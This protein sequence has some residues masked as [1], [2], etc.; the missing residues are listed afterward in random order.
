[1]EEKYGFKIPNWGSSLCGA[2]ETNL[3]GIREDAG[4]IPGLTHWVGN[5]V[6]L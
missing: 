1:M 3:T 5:P 2:A 6:L 4:L